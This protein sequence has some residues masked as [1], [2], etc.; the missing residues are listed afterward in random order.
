[1]WYSYFNQFLCTV[2]AGNDAD[3]W[4]N[5]RQFNDNAKKSA[6]MGF[7]FDSTPVATEITA[8]QNVYDEYQKSLEFGF[9]DP[10]V[11]I[12]EMNEKM[13]RAGLQKIIDEKQRQL[14]EWAAQK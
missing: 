14:D 2:T 1:M 5:I 7:T 10:S 11:G 3:L 12:P 8:V 4:D 13:M 9:V 6:A